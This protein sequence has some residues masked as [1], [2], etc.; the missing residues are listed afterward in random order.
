MLESPPKNPVEGDMYFNHE[1][2]VVFVMGKE[3]KWL[4]RFRMREAVFAP[5]MEVDLPLDMVPIGL[6]TS[7]PDNPNKQLRFLYLE[8]SAWHP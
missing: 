6:G 7:T 1:Q 8:P 3:G 2:N 4:V 5:N